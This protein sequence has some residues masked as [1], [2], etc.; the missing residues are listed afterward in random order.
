MS[1]AGRIHDPSFSTPFSSMS[2]TVFLSAESTFGYQAIV[3]C[4]PLFFFFRIYTVNYLWILHLHFVTNYVVGQSES[5]TSTMIK[6]TI[7]HD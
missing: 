2:V 6:S 7:P 1:E 4:F 3:I 5:A